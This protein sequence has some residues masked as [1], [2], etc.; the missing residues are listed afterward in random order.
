MVILITGA[1]HTGKTLLAQRLLERLRYPC[2]SIDHLKMGLIRSGNTALTPEDDDALTEYLWPIVREMVKTAIENRQNLIVEGCYV[3]FGWRRD[4]DERYMP[5]IRFVCLAMPDAYIAA[6]FE[7]IRAHASDIEARLDDSACTVDR[8]RADNRAFAEGFRKSG[9]PIAWI[10]GDFGEAMDGIV[11]RLAA[12]VK[13]RCRRCGACCRIP[14]G[15]VRVSDA[16]IGRI[17][18]FLGMTE[19]EFIERETEIAP[20]RRGL[21][22]KS[23]PDGACAWLTGDNL[24]RINP[25][26][27]DKCRTFPLEWTNSDSREIC[28]GLGPAASSRRAIAT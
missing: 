26:K 14:N 25:V 2:L 19:A 11:G 22:L 17:A 3:P 27:P 6:H 10:D 28:P 12:D 20:D 24:C 8:L 15:I 21:I 5:S 1:S 7:E 18:A 4:F 9:E 23:R 13:F 16:E